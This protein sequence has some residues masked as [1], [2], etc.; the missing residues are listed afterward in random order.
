MKSAKWFK[1]LLTTGRAR[2]VL[3]LA[4]GRKPPR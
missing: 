2:D 1:A 3:R 4:V